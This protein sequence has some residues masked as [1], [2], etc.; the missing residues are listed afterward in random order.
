MTYSNRLPFTCRPGF[1]LCGS[2]PFYFASCSGVTTMTCTAHNQFLS[3]LYVPSGSSVEQSHVGD[4]TTLQLF[5]EFRTK[6][7]SVLPV[8]FCMNPTHTSPGICK[9]RLMFG[10]SS[11]VTYCIVSA[12]FHPPWLKQIRYSLSAMAGVL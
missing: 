10:R 5:Q 7:L 11:G 3:Q 4:C 1:T 9:P 8:L 2:Q 6:T 12:R